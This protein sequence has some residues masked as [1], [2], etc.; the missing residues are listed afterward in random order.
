MIE[1]YSFISFAM[2]ELVKGI[3]PSAVTYGNSKIVQYASPS[4]SNMMMELVQANKLGLVHH[5]E[6]NAQMIINAIEA[7][8]DKVYNC[9]HDI[10]LAVCQYF[11]PENSNG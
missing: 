3:F 7:G 2:W 6:V 10:A 8:I 5:S 1:R 11:A 4:D 9:N